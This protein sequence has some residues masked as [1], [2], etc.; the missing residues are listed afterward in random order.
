MAIGKVKKIQKIVTKTK[1]NPKAAKQS[2]EVNP[3]AK[4]MPKTVA[5]RKFRQR[6]MRKNV[7]G[8]QHPLTRAERQ[9]KPLRT[10]RSRYGG[11]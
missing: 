8:G 3:Y 7:T 4:V 11:R 10:A 5:K 6:P 1:R 9:D 2:T